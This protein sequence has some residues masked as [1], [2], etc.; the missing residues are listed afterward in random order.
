MDLRGK[1]KNRPNKLS[2]H[3]LFKIKTHILS[4]PR[5]ISHYSRHD[6]ENKRFLSSELSISKLYSLYL[7]KY[8]FDVF[9]KL[10]KG[11]KVK[12]TVKYEFFSQYFNKNFNLSFGY[13][14][15][16][17]CQTCDHLQN[18][19]NAELDIELKS[20]LIDEKQRHVE[21][22][23]TFYTD[24]KN[25]SKESRLNDNIEVLSFDYQQNMPLPH[26]PCGDVFYKRQLWSYNFCVYSGKL[27]QGYFFI[28]YDETVGKKGQNEVISLN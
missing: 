19:I 10:K 3:I 5:Y 20:N 11:E 15:T 2:D 8:E 18:V 6:N 14:K 21:K 16:D 13:P 1:H 12:P 4:F 22:A 25:L 28:M 9:E 27:R 23:S 17:T 26:I 7:E 24:L